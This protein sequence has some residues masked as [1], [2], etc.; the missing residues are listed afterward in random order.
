M[1]VVVITRGAGETISLYSY[2]NIIKVEVLKY[3][4]IG[5]YRDTNKS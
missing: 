1:F 4:D 2:M 5:L 3:L